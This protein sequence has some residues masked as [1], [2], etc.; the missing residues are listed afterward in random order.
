[1]L[2]GNFPPVST[3]LMPLTDADI[4]ESYRRLRDFVLAERDANAAEIRNMWVRPLTDRVARGWSVPGMTV[5]NIERLSGASEFLIS[6][7]CEQDESRFREGD[8]VK[9]TYDQPT[10]L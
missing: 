6:L 1:M 3:S 4:L 2:A 5:S 10:Q 8:Y 7:L 9:L